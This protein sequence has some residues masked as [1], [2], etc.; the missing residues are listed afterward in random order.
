MCKTINGLHNNSAN[1]KV[2]WIIN[3]H[4]AGSMACFS[5]RG[6]SYWLPNTHAYKIIVLFVLQF[7]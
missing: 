2:Q 5:A 6:I 3:E 4:K 7:K 1:C